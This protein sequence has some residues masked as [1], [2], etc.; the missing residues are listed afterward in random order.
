[1]ESK[2][3]QTN[4]KISVNFNIQGFKDGQQTPSNEFELNM[5]FNFKEESHYDD[6]FKAFDEAISEVESVGSE[7]KNE[8]PKII[9]ELQNMQK[10]GQVPVICAVDENTYDE[11]AK[12]GKF[13]PEYKVDESKDVDEDSP[14]SSRGFFEFG[15]H[16]G[17][18]GFGL[19]SRL[20]GPVTASARCN[21][22]FFD[23]NPKL[24]GRLTTYQNS[25]ALSNMF[26]HV[27]FSYEKNNEN[28]QEE[29]SFSD[30]VTYSAGLGYNSVLGKNKDIRFVAELG[31]ELKH[32]DARQGRFSGIKPYISTSV[33]FDI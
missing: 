14:I 29:T 9:A 5:D 19:E 20:F 31:A 25:I 16:D 10:N 4:P 30:G 6:F 15:K 22:N 8:V 28:K 21:A 3:V 1:M 2:S 12:D 33:Q 18:F 7:L 26:A 23:R 11:L 32:G 27:G 17:F 13:F 24:S